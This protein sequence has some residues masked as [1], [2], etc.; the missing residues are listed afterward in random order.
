MLGEV[1]STHSFMEGNR[2]ITTKLSLYSKIEKRQER[3][4]VVINPSVFLRESLR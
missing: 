1:I 2:F 3:H 4:C